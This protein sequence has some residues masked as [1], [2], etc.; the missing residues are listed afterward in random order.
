M[1]YLSERHSGCQAE[2]NAKGDKLDLQGILCKSTEKR[3]AA[4]QMQSDPCWKKIS[5]TDR[6]FYRDRSLQLGKEAANLYQLLHATDTMLSLTEQY[7]LS[8]QI[9]KES[10]LDSLLPKVDRT[11]KRIVINNGKI[12]ML[13]HLLNQFNIAAT[14]NEL[15]Q[16]VFL[17]GFYFFFAEANRLLPTE[18]LPVIRVVQLKLF[19]SDEVMQSSDMV[20]ADHFC[21]IVSGFPIPL[22]LLSYLRWIESGHATEEQL[23][24]LLESKE[25][26]L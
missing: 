18:N 12:E 24:K 4:L 7:N 13:L 14:K 9:V 11:R 6:V 3:L 22:Y 17:R 23:I 16:A 20:A 5:Q 25:V 15:I 2:A 26:N 8:L 19:H 1:Q 21:Y 10:T